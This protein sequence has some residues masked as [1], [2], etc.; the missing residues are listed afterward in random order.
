MDE[1]TIKI[2]QNMLK[3]ELRKDINS[4]KNKYLGVKEDIVKWEHVNSLSI[5]SRNI[6]AKNLS[7]CFMFLINEQLYRER[8]I[9]TSLYKEVTNDCLKIRNKTV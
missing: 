8:L 6:S 2:T 9:S 3:N 7:D 1:D 4:L 5:R